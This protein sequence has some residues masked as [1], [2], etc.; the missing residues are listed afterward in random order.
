MSDLKF[1]ENFDNPYVRISVFCKVCSK[2]QSLKYQHTWKRHFL[3]HS[4]KDDLPNKCPHCGK[5]F[6][7][8]HDMRKHVERKHAVLPVKS[9]STYDVFTPKKYEY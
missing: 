4:S 3:T 1:L 2:E 6:I 9:D 7:Q 8:A 5:G